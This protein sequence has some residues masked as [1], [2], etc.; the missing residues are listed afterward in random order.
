MFSAQL[1]EHASYCQLQVARLAMVDA[2]QN[3][4]LALRLDGSISAFDR[5]CAAIA[6][7]PAKRLKKLQHKAAVWS[8]R[9]EQGARS[10]L[11]RSQE[12]TRAAMAAQ[13][14]IES[15]SLRAM[16]VWHR[17]RERGDELH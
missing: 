6:P 4:L 17:Q 15:A 9:P 2:E 7:E 13:H 11:S 10:E 16:S 5:A 12:A 8:E 14:K 3:E 1:K